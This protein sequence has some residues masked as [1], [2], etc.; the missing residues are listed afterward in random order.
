MS[1]CPL[2]ALP[3]YD[4]ASVAGGQSEPRMFVVDPQT[5][6]WNWSCLVKNGEYHYPG[7]DCVPAN[8]LVKYG[9]VDLPTPGL[10]K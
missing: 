8:S 5:T 9:G 10:S 7:P 1:H 4:L 6:V 3:A 2:R